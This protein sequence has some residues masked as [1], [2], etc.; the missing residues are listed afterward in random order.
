MGGLER[1]KQVGFPND[2]S[3]DV[4]VFVGLEFE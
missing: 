3:V 4:F 1:A 2:E